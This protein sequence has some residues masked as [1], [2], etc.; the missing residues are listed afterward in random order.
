[1]SPRKFHVLAGAF[2]AAFLLSSCAGYRLGSMLPPGI[3][4]VYIPTVEN[5]STEPRIEIIATRE[6]MKEV[7]MEGSLKVVREKAQAD[8][9]LAIKIVHYVL[10]PVSYQSNINNTTANEYRLRLFA[11][12]VLTGKD[13]KVLADNK[14][15]YGESTFP[16]VGDFT[17]SKERGLPEA[18]KDL[19]RKAIQACTEAW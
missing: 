19:A 13:D 15:V 6:I 8:A 7:Q 1:M 14:S 10:E 4:T 18:S 2:A 3:K 11:E 17:S 9:V 5:H 16:I 12:V